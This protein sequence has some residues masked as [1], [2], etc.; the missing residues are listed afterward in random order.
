LNKAWDLLS[1]FK[2]EKLS[3]INGKIKDEYFM[4][5]NR[6]FEENRNQINSASNKEDK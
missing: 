1:L 2:K 3:K 6:E 5:V 4:K